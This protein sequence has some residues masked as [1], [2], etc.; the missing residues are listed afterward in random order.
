MPLIGKSCRLG[1]N[2]QTASVVAAT[3]NAARKPKQAICAAV[4]FN[5]Q[6]ASTAPTSSGT[7][8]ARPRRPDFTSVST[9][10][11]CPVPT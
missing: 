1:N 7:S 11:L 8:A 2:A 5:A 10:M 4:I 3:K 9:T 6:V